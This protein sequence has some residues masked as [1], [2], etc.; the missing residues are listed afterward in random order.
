[1]ANLKKSFT[2]IELLVVI[3]II[4]IL[5]SMLLPALSKARERAKAVSCINNLKSCGQMFL[6]YGTDYEGWY[7]IMAANVPWA[8]FLTPYAGE[9]TVYYKGTSAKINVC[10]YCPSTRPPQGTGN[11]RF[12][13]YAVYNAVNDYNPYFYTICSTPQSH[14]D[15]IHA[16]YAFDGVACVRPEKFENPSDTAHVLDSASRDD[17]Q[18]GY[19]KWSSFNWTNGDIGEGT[20]ALRHSRK[21]NGLFFDGH[22]S[23]FNY[24]E[25]EKLYIPPYFDLTIL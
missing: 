7:P 23:S 5:A 24:G 4:A 6:L 10:A 14:Y 17:N 18:S 15:T 9:K 11:A 25:R 12:T 3:A 13:S 22:C 2:L 19:W 1:M 8:E 16:A 20:A 21:C